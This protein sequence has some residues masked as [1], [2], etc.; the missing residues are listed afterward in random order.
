VLSLAELCAITFAGNS[1]LASTKKTIRLFIT[2]IPNAKEKFVVA[3]I[4]YNMVR[5]ILGRN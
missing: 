5:V 3:I 2:S 4:C 1:K